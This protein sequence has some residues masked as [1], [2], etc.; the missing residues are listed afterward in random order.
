MTRR[1]A[2]RIRPSLDALEAREVP[3]GLL[4]STWAAAAHVGQAVAGP[5]IV[6]LKY[7]SA[8]TVVNETKQTLRFRVQWEGQGRAQAYELAPGQSKVVWTPEVGKWYPHREAVVAMGPGIGRLP[9]ASFGV[10]S[11]MVPHTP[12]GPAQGGPAYVFQPA[13]SG[14]IQLAGK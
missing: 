5:K 10:T 1:P 3:A 6:L 9:V 2:N 11:D 12:H 7:A 4:Q 14:T 13:A 8:F